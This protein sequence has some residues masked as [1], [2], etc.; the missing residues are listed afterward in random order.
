M[1][2]GSRSW[3]LVRDAA[4]GGAAA[5]ERLL[6]LDPGITAVYTSTVSQAAG[7]LSRA[8]RLGLEVPTRLSVVAHAEM[9]LADYLV[10]PLTTV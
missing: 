7:V 10:P 3:T 5:L 4:A 2:L 6:E 8:W 9:P 1:A